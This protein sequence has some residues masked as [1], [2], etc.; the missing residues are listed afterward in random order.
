MPACLRVLSE[1]AGF[2]SFS[3]LNNS[4]RSTYTAATFSIHS[5]ANTW[6]VLMSWLLWLGLQQT[7]ERAHFLIP[8]F[9]FL[10]L[11]CQRG[12]AGAY[13]NSIFNFWGSAVLFSIGTAPVHTPTNRVWGFAFLRVPVTTC[14]LFSMID[15][16]AG[17]SWYLIMV[18]ISVSLMISDADFFSF[19]RLPFH[20]IDGFL[21]CVEVFQLDVVPLDGSCSW[22]WQVLG[23][24]D[25]KELLPCVFFW[26]LQAMSCVY[27][28][29][30]LQV[31][32]CF[33]IL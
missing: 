24:T 14:H 19:S 26:V 31:H 8:C 21:C 4:P 16:R 10:W 1:M 6:T 15:I 3:W 13:G 20:F 33:G 27:V 11:Y 25:V 18:V 17:I 12:V 30:K 7:W 9:H 22:P 28:F 2:P 32:F 23:K 5:L 29:N